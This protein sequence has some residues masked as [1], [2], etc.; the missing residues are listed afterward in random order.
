MLEQ[1]YGLERPRALEDRTWRYELVNGTQA[2]LSAL[3]RDPRVSDTA[4]LD[5]QT[6][7]LI[8]RQPDW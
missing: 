6:G 1:Q 8:Q 7:A 4:G 5:R 2:N 3:I